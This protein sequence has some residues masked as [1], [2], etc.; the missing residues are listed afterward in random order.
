MEHEGGGRAYPEIGIPDD[1]HT[2]SHHQNNPVSIDK[3]VQIHRYHMKLF[4]YYLER[5]GSVPDGNGNLLDN[6]ILLYGS[7]LSD[8]NSHLHEN[9][10]VLLVGG[11]AGGIKGGR[12][13]RYPDQ[14]PMTNLHLAVL[15]KL[16]VPVEKLGDSTG[17]INLLSV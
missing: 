2:L 4:A 14:T 16:G 17:E 7:A 13:L 15:D 12:H 6:M 5:L 9:L 3:L 10:P 8:G 11:A 1:H